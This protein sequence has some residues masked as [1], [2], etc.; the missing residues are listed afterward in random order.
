M[1]NSGITQGIDMRIALLC[2]WFLAAAANADESSMPTKLFGVELGAHYKIDEDGFLVGAP[3]EAV[4]KFA[5]SGHWSGLG[6]YCWFK[7]NK[8]YD[9]YKYVEWYKEGN[10]DFKTSFRLYLLPV[11]T[12]ASGY[13]A[14]SSVQ[15]IELE[16]ARIE[17]SNIHPVF[18]NESE[19]QQAEQHAERNRN[20]D[21]LGWAN[22]LCENIAVDLEMPNNLR[23]SEDTRY[24]NFEKDGRDLEVEG[25]ND[26]G[27]IVLEYSH[28]VLSAKHAELEKLL[29]KAK[30]KQ[31]RPYE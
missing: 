18:L 24:C 21:W 10:Q 4:T 15:D 25:W 19:R 30:M 8:E 14:A 22:N 1:I 9:D 29:R 27:K 13:L 28:E 16:V 5:R 2:L 20:I 31:S 6:F 23:G 17:W 3:I 7:P 11:I 26:G 12:D